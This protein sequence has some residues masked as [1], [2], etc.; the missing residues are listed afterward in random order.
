MPCRTLA[1]AALLSLPV[2]FAF[3]GIP[4]AAMAQATRPS[5]GEGLTRV[6]EGVFQLRQGKSV[7][8]TKHAILLTV[9]AEQSERDFERSQFYVMIAGNSTRA[10][11]GDRIDLRRIRR[12]ERDL[13]SKDQCYLDVVDFVAPRGAPATATFRI[14]CI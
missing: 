1:R 10:K 6:D 4:G 11:V 14:N 5:P 9:R 13:K 7:D 12:L 8:L 2:I 3:A